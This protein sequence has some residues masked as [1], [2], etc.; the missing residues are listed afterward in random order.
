MIAK[1]V[2]YID[3]DIYL[4]AAEKLKLNIEIYD[5]E[6]SY[7]RIYNDEKELYIRGITL[8]VN[9][10]VPIRTA[11]NK[12]LTYRILHKN[13]LPVPKQ[14]LFEIDETDKI[15]GYCEQNFPVVIKPEDSSLGKGV[16][17][18]INST[19]E[20]EPAIQEVSLIGKKK[21]L[22][23]DYVKGTDY[24]ILIYRNKI[25]DVLKRIPPYVI[26]DGEKSIKE[27]IASKN[28]EREKLR[29]KLIQ[30]DKTVENF[31]Q[32]QKLN[33]N[34]VLKKGHKV[35]VRP[36]CNFALGGETK[37]IDIKKIHPDTKKMF[38]EVFKYSKL[39]LCGIDY[40]TEN[41]YESYKKV[42]G[43]INE[44]NGCPNIYIHY[45]ADMKESLQIPKKILK[46]FFKL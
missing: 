9:N 34:S 37:R 29:L 6:Y 10:Y 19:D 2:S 13:D 12:H 4:S 44:N 23:E 14:K 31:L 8:G 30:V 15:I 42:G 3:T 38:L 25:L 24:R 22:V 33:L 43:Y 26:G 32:D 28:K 27:L 21:V 11:E 17:V 45:F 39:N 46:M 18:N 35:E 5:K 41:I 16:T 36:T 1:K 7:C 20:I 40:I